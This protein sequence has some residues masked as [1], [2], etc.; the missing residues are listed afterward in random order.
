MGEPYRFLPDSVTPMLIRYF[1]F[2]GKASGKIPTAER[3]REILTEHELPV[4]LL[5]YECHIHP[6]EKLAPPNTGH[7]LME[8]GFFI[9]KVLQKDIGRQEAEYLLERGAERILEAFQVTK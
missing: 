5:R 1:D 4:S 6:H 9:L 3:A 8:R 2:T 7:V